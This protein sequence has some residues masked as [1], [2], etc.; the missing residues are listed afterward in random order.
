MPLKT[1]GVA[2]DVEQTGNV[3]DIYATKEAENVAD[4]YEFVEVQGETS[5]EIVEGTTEVIILLQNKRTNNYNT[6]NN[7]RK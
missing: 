1:G 2:E 3:G 5:G 7:K 4:N 6:T